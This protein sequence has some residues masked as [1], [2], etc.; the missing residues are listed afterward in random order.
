MTNS[1]ANQNNKQGDCG[2]SCKKSNCKRVEAGCTC[3]QPCNCDPCTCDPC[4]CCKSSK[5]CPCCKCDPCKCC[6]SS[7]CC[8][9]CK[10]DPCKCK[11]H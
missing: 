1:T 4:K 10:C 6:N 3:T 2:S 7:K 11:S 8:P 5:C 9:C